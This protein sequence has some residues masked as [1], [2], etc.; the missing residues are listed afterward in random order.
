MAEPQEFE[1][2]LGR[3]QIA[4]LLFVATIILM[5]CVAISYLAWKIDVGLA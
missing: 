3:R 2:V 4:S 1:F 5:I